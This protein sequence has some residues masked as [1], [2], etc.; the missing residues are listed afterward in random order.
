MADPAHALCVHD[1]DRLVGVAGYHSPAGALVGGGLSDLAAVYGWAGSLWRAAALSVLE[2]PRQAGDLLVDGIF[3]AP[4]HR[5][6]GLGSALIE[7]LAREAV[8]RGCVRVRLDVIDENA[9][10]RALY[11][12]KGFVAVGGQSSRL[13]KLLFGFRG[14]VTMVRQV[15]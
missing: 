5:G 10:A 3:V 15:A 1:G 12:R 11:E 9:R 4:S 13:L 8:A 6:H 7:G 2:R 14:A